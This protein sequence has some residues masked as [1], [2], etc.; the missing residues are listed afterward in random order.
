[1]V[2][3]YGDYSLTETVNIP[4]N[5][6][7]S[8]DPSASVTV[9]DLVAG[10]IYVHKDGTEGT[11]TGITVSLNVGT[12]NGNHLA[13]LDLTDTNDAGFYANGSRYQ[14][15]MEGVT[16][17]GET[18]NAWIGA[19]SIGCTLRPTTAG[20]TLDVTATG[21]AGADIQT[22]K[23]QT[24]TC[25]AGVTVLASVGAAAAPGAADGMLIGGTNAATTFN[26]LTVT[27]NLLVSGTTTLTGVVALGPTT[28]TNVAGIGLT[29]SGTTAGL[30]STGTSGHGIWGASTGVGAQH[31]GIFGQSDISVTGVGIRA[32]GYLH[33]ALI[34][35]GTGAS[36]GGYGLRIINYG[37][38]P[39]L[40]IAGGNAGVS[41]PL[42]S[43][44]GAT[45][46]RDA[47]YFEAVGTGTGVSIVGTI[48]VDI[49]ATGYGV[50]I[51]S[52]GTGADSAVHV[53]CSNGDG[54]RYIGAGTG[55]M[56]MLLWGVQYG[57]QAYASGAASTGIYSNATAS[58]M[59][60]AGTI[61][62]E[63]ST[64]NVLGT[65]TLTG[66]VS[67]PAGI[68]A[69]IT[70]DITG[71]LSGSVGTLSGPVTLA[72]GVSHGGSTATLEL[73]A[74]GAAGALRITNSAGAALVIAGTTRGISASA[75]AGYGAYFS[76]TVAGA[77]CLG[78]A[79]D[80]HGALFVN[81]GG[82]GIDISGDITGNITGNLLTL[83]NSM[84]AGL[85]FGTVD[86]GSFTSTS[87][88]FESDD[89]AEPTADHYN[90]RVIVFTS[91]VLSGQACTINDY[92]LSG[93]NGHF[94]VSELTDLPGNGDAFTIY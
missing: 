38:F 56:G 31:S 8:D 14:V 53:S 21:E 28:I 20:R 18:V 46:N 86:T 69:D 42:V 26:A 77:Y 78:S 50:R 44:S 23:T 15:R 27:N 79:A 1:M 49:D 24:V 63:T 94:T 60:L 82:S 35:G 61:G 43:V 64:L 90:G 9:T 37:D 72:D 22:I 36:A 85:V 55:S 17:D 74:A 58:G 30:K 65:T 73:G 71:N 16:I 3:F 89:I 32:N 33:G 57:L 59:K 11:P 68:T 91:G 81:G 80:G 5:T 54:V 66:A 92:A 84:V 13:I 19:F 12:V 83:L 6:F 39:V 75:S 87:T 47:I 29:I 4:F 52:D 7:S 70:G 76:G 62:L 2:S 45:G 25:A 88:E 41:T 48:G 93:A 10:D 51:D 67:A 40:D 34:E